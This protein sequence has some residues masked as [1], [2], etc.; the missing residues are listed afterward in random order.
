MAGAALKF[1]WRHDRGPCPTD[2]WLEAVMAIVFPVEN[3]AVHF[4]DTNGQSLSNIVTPLQIGIGTVDSSVAGWCPS[5]RGASG[6][7]ALKM[8]KPMWIW[9]SS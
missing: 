9:T 7:V 8:S 3:L 6:N 2:S 5:A 4:D 1:S